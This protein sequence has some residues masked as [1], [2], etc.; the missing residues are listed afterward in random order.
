MVLKL[1]DCS[2]KGIVKYHW[3]KELFLTHRCP[4][5]ENSAPVVN[6]NKISYYSLSQRSL[7]FCAQRNHIY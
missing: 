1:E 7:H 5:T 4:F 3:I 6:I 2:S